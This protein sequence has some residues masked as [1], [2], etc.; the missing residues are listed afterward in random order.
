MPKMYVKFRI[1]LGFWF[2]ELRPT[3]NQ[4]NTK[5]ISPDKL[6]S[7]VTTTRYAL[8]KKVHKIKNTFTQVRT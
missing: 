8:Y 6:N 5:S 1:L 3:P 4:R 7:C 2:P